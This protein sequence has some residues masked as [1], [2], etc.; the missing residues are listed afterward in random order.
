MASVAKLRQSTDAPLQGAMLA[1]IILSA[2]WFLGVLEAF[3]LAR[4]LALPF[5]FVLGAILGNWFVRA[6]RWTALTLL[7]IVA[8]GM[9]SPI[10]EK[11]AAPLVRNDAVNL[12]T[13][14]A[15]FVM[16][17][18]VNSRGLLA[19]EGVD[20]L[21][22]GIQ[23]RAKKPTLPLVVSIVNFRERDS[24][25]SS[26]ADQRAL[27]ALSPAPGATEF[28]D[29]VYSTRDEAVG[30]AQK[31][32]VR[33]WKRVAVVTSPTHTRRA[34]ATVEETGLAVTC[35]MA[36]WRV[37]GWPPKSANDRRALMQHLTY[38]TLAWTQYRLSGWA[39]W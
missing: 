30:L 27:I 14:D 36:P 34:C 32:L 29:S 17:N 9:W 6:L 12:E 5:A 16:S 25:P 28:I 26:Q 3:S 23:L 7:L 31:A 24:G 15:I 33:R 1:L 20:R 4:P 37:V 21:I 11:M 19:G 22:A 13:I 18:A 38:E 8:I 39:A 10:V 35:V 2:L